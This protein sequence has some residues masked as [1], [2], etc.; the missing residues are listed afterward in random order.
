MSKTI[1]L[2][3]GTPT[4]GKSTTAQAV[5][6]HFNIPWISTDQIREI[7]RTIADRKQYPKLFTPK[8]YTT[9]RFL[10]EFSAEEIAKMEYEQGEA[11]W[12]GIKKLINDDYTW[13]DGFV[14]EGVNLLPHLIAKDFSDN[15]N[16]KAV[17]LGDSDTERMRRVIYTRGLWD[18]AKSYSDDVKEKEV[19]WALLFSKL[20][21]NDAT[22]HDY[23]WIEIQK[24]ESDLEKVLQALNT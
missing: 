12:V 4:V 11:A 14:I 15:P 9:E 21:R 13:T 22:M 1:I 2:I 10:T 23:P 6:N 16:I 8:D 7:M 20:L 18:D 17:F 5:A 24:N 19:E 3:G